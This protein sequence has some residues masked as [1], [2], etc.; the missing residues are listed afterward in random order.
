MQETTLTFDNQLLVVSGD[1]IECPA[2]KTVVLLSM[3]QEFMVHRRKMVVGI[4]GD[5]M[6]PCT[7]HEDDHFIHVGCLKE[8]KSDFQQKFIQLLQ[9]KS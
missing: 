9:K 8:L 4:R 2:K 1:T 7:I 3:I 5:T 6:E